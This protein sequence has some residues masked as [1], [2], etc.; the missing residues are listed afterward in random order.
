MSR[1]RLI[2]NYATPDLG[3]FEE[4]A[5]AASALTERY[6]VRL[7]IS[8]YAYKDRSQLVDPGDPYLEYSANFPDLFRFAPRT[9]ADS[10][11]GSES[12]RP[13][14]AVKVFI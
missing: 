14:I 3:R 8:H 9:F 12:L 13:V 4:V 11:P 10:V 1:P 6:D 5:S 2:L 7:V